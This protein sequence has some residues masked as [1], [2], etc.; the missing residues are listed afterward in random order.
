MKT[1]LEN[2]IIKLGKVLQEEN[3]SLDNIDT[4]SLEMLALIL[5]CEVTVR[6]TRVLH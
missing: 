4:E 5:N 2:A 1:D 6:N 3:E